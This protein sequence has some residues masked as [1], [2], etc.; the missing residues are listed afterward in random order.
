LYVAGFVGFVRAIG[1]EGSDDA[2][3]LKSGIVFPSGGDAAMGSPSQAVVNY[4]D[5][6]TQLDDGMLDLACVCV[7]VYDDV[8]C[9]Y[10]DMGAPLDDG[11]LDLACVCVYNDVTCVY[12]DVTFPA[13]LQVFVHSLPDADPGTASQADRFAAEKLKLG[14]ADQSDLKDELGLDGEDFAFAMLNQL[15]AME[16]EW[17]QNGSS[18]DKANFTYI[19]KGRARNPN[20]IPEHTKQEL[21]QLGGT[22][23]EDFDFGHDGMEAKD[24]QELEESK[25]AGLQL[26]HVVALRLYTSNSYPLFN[27]PIREGKK[28]HPIRVTMYVLDEALKKMRKNEARQDPEGYNRTLRLWRGMRDRD[29]DL[30]KFKREGGT[31]LA[32]MSTSAHRS[33]AEKFARGD[34]GGLIF[35]YTTRA[36]SKGVCIDFLSLYPKEKEYM[37]PPLTYLTFDEHAQD[38]AED[39]AERE[40]E[41]ASHL[42]VIH[43]VPQWS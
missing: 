27:D 42:K 21:A 43:V 17:F 11:M 41:I 2:L 5:G 6:G 8:T 23:E 40:R 30:D 10:N 9:V 26:H 25:T 32:V 18:T 16:Q 7:C 37:Y 24:F 1:P 33:V 20:D 14:S 4:D 39:P 29:L 28:P 3:D 19:T 15:Q 13:P 31:E 38:E 12:D 35:R 34:K 36:H 22:A